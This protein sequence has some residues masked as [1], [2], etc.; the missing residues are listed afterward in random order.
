MHIYTH[1][2]IPTHMHTHMCTSTHAHICTFMHMYTDI[3]AHPHTCTHT[4]TTNLFKETVNGRYCLYISLLNV[5]HSQGFLS[6]LP[7][8]KTFL[9]S[10]FGS[11]V[12]SAM[13]LWDMILLCSSGWIWTHDSPASIPLCSPVL[14]STDILYHTQL[15]QNFNVI[16]CFISQ[17]SMCAFPFCT[18]DCRIVYS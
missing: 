5:N 18:L 16:F 9:R 14:G 1:M 13:P 4:Q 3:C 15:I 17:L 12:D 7:F 6:F 10:L 11:H 2:C 8:P